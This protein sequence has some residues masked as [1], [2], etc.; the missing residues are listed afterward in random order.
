MGFGRDLAAAMTFGMSATTKHKEA[1]AKYETRRKEHQRRLN[2]Y[3]EVQAQLHSSDLAQFLIGGDKERDITVYIL[4][5]PKQETSMVAGTE[6]PS[7]FPFGPPPGTSWL[8][9]K[10]ELRRWPYR[11]HPLVG[12]ASTNWFSVRGDSAAYGT[13]HLAFCTL[14]RALPARQ[15]TQHRSD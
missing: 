3:N 9:L 7:A 4:I 11:W 5:H 6:L 13:Q 8:H 10:I 15:S 14:H 2:S 1:Q 12:I